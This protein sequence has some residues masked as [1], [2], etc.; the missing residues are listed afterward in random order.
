M[1]I[2]VLINLLDSFYFKMR[3][4]MASIRQDSDRSAKKST[5]SKN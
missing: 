1:Q 5:N 2:C 3:N 4:S